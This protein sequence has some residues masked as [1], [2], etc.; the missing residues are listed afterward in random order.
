MSK[1]IKYQILHEASNLQ[2]VSSNLSVSH[3]VICNKFFWFM[4]YLVVLL[5][6][7]PLLS[8]AQVHARTDEEV[9]LTPDKH[10]IFIVI[11]TAGINNRQSGRVV[12][13]SIG[14]AQPVFWYR[15][16]QRTRHGKIEYLDARG[17]KLP[18]KLMIVHMLPLD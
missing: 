11:D 5:L 6:M 4:K 7:L 14:G 10:V 8:K 13:D 2:G 16:L 1:L 15:G 18:E 9:R 3:F 12:S 17:A